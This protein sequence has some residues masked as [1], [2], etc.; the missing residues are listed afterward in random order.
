VILRRIRKEIMR[1]L[2]QKGTPGEQR[3][4]MDVSLI[5]INPGERRVR[6]A[7]AYNSLYLVRERRFAAPDIEGMKVMEEGASPD[8]LMYE[9][10]ADRMPVAFFDRMDKFTTHSFSI[11]EGDQLYLYTDGYP[12]Q[13]GGERGKKFKYK[14]F[15]ELILGHAS[16]GMEDQFQTLSS[17]LD[18]WKGDYDQV[19]DICMI[20]VRF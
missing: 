4:G 2:G 6:Y 12:D 3:D 1:S 20:G 8:H 17:T 19:D 7:G 11:E 10:P 14:P 18:D 13:F 15:K 9:I 5:E 16:L